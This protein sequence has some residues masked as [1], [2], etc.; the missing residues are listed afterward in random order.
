[1]YCLKIAIYPGDDIVYDREIGT[2]DAIRYGL[3]LIAGLGRQRCADLLLVM[4]QDIDAKTLRC[5][6]L[7]PAR[8]F[9]IGK[10]GDERWRQG[11]R[12]EGADGHADRFAFVDR[13]DRA[14]ARRIV[15]EDVSKLEAVEAADHEDLNP[16][17]RVPVS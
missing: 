16:V 3:E 17:W 2:G 14:D 12:C 8:R 6:N 10:E 5:C 4:T 1:M 15:A 7:L 9:S 11:D 13:R